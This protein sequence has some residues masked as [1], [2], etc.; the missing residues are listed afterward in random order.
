MLKNLTT[1][2]ALCAA[3][4]ACQPTVPE[5]THETPDAGAASS[6]PHVSGAEGKRL[7]WVDAT[8]ALV[9]EQLL[10]V[11]A[12]GNIWQLDPETGKAFAPQ[13]LAAVTSNEDFSVVE[14]VGVLAPVLSQH[15]F[16]VFYRGEDPTPT[17][18]DDGDAFT[19]DSREDRF[20]VRLSAASLVP[21]D[22]DGA[23][24]AGAPTLST[25]EGVEQMLA[26]EEVT[27]ISSAPETPFTGP[28]RHILR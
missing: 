4:S 28:L 3:L 2:A 10:H 14:S 17:N 22:D 6:V 7:V 27:W 9:G 23:V 19:G 12:D 20:G 13:A 26:I 1:L 24:G 21:R 5:H 16:R 18:A 11:D 15:V 25:G 8:G